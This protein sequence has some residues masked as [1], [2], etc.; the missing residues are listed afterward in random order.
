MGGSKSFRFVTRYRPIYNTIARLDIDQE[1]RDEIADRLAK[2]IGESFQEPEQ[3]AWYRKEAADFKPSL[4]RLL[5]S[6]PLCLC[7]GFGDKPCPEQRE[8]RI[9]MHLSSAPDGRSAAWAQRKPVVR[10][11]S[12]GAKEFVPGHRVLT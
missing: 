3:W 7:A 12:C 6:D 2:A 4:F 1:L 11:V 8:I 10:C 5:A 9:G